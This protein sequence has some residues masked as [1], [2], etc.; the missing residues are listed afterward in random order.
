M[1][2]IDIFLWGVL[3]YVALSILVVVSVVRRVVC[4][5]TWT[6]KSSEFL[7]KKQE[8]VATPLFHVAIMFVLFGHLGGLFIPKAVTDAIGVSEHMYHMV[9]FIMGGIAGTGVCVG[10][11][12]LIRRRFGGNKRMK[13]NTTMMDKVLYVALGVTIAL[14]MASTLS[15]AEGGFV[16]RETLAPWVRSIFMLQP[17]PSL[18]ADTPLVYKAHILCAMGTFM[19]LPFTRLV[20]ML[21]GITAPFRS[22]G[23]SAVLYREREQ[24]ALSDERDLELPRGV[25]MQ[26]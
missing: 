14:G 24:V 17:D 3:P 8:R 13:A 7:E 5:R 10:L 26:R 11:L 1:S 23:R 20:H 21:S 12:L 2:G 6:A 19:L 16:Y 15:N 25:H 4:A 9:A 22:A 18:M